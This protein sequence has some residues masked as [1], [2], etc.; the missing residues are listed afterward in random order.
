MAEKRGAS[1]E[2][3]GELAGHG[4]FHG[5]QARRTARRQAAAAD[6]ARGNEHALRANDGGDPIQVNDTR[7]TVFTPGVPVP[8]TGTF[9]GVTQHDH[10]PGSSNSTLSSRVNPAGR[11][12]AV[13]VR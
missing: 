6:V 4:N 12:R 3:P 11:T 13:T 7:W 10:W 8:G 5:S 1:G 2:D 9:A